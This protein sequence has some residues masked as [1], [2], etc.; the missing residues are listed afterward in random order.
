MNETKDLTQ[1]TSQDCKEKNESITKILELIDKLT[2]K[3]L[4]ILVKEIEKKY[5]I[6]AALVTSN[7]STSKEDDDTEK[8]IEKKNKQIS[9]QSI[10]SKMSVIKILTEAFLKHANTKK[11]MLEVSK[12]LSTLPSKISFTTDGLPENIAQEISDK[13]T[14]AGASVKLEDI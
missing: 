9:I 3:D 14:E 10:T 4:S 5:D 12:L 11:T 2:V 6:S 13:I 8:T 1:N 7:Q